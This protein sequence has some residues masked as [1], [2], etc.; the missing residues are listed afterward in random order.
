MAIPLSLDQVQDQTPSVQ[1]VAS[2]GQT[3]FP[4]PFAITQ[5]S[6]L[7]VYVNGIAQQTDQGYSLTGQ[8]NDTGGNVISNAGLTAGTIVTLIRDVPIER[9]TQFSQNGGFSSSA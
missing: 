6:D 9:L 5:D 2:A 3:V 4:Y 8:G 1:Y 7:V